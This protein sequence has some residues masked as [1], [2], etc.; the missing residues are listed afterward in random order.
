M[1]SDI[2]VCS[3]HMLQNLSKRRSHVLLFSMCWFWL[4]KLSGTYRSTSRV[5]WW[6]LSSCGMKAF[7]LDAATTALWSGSIVLYV[8]IPFP[9]L[10]PYRTV[11]ELRV[12]GPVWGSTSEG[13]DSRLPFAT[14][15]WKQ[16]ASPLGPKNTWTERPYSM[17]IRQML[18]SLSVPSDKYNLSRFTH[19]SYYLRDCTFRHWHCQFTFLT[20]ELWLHCP[21]YSSPA[22]PSPTMVKQLA[23][24]I[25]SLDTSVATCFHATYF[26]GA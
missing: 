15:L 22:L 5:S 12:V 20:C 21:G 2:A 18:Q 19:T 8:R 3:L 24:S 1:T 14:L 16:L 9:S 10:Q 25:T 13:N 17:S 23:T 11:G 7:A 4:W 6:L 26:C